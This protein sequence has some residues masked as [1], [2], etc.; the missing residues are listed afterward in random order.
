MTNLVSIIFPV[1]PGSRGARR[2]MHDLLAQTWED[3]EIVTVLNGCPDEIR[4]SFQKEKSQRVKL[5]DLGNEPNL[6]KALQVATEAACGV[7]L[8][9]MDTDDRCHPE[10]IEKTMEL[11]LAGECDVASC[12]I[13]LIDPIGNGM[14][15]YVDW[16]NQLTDHERVSA[17]RFIESPVVQPTVILRR[18]TFFE[19][20]GYLDDGF[21][22]DY[23]LWLRLLAQG[24]RFG[25]VS[26]LLYSWRDHEDRLTRNDVRFSQK[27]MLALKADALSRLDEVIKRGV[28]FCGA[29]PIAKVLA[30]ELLGRGIAVHGFFEIDPKR[31]GSICQ[32]QPI[33][34]HRDF[35]TRWRDAV[36]LAAV[37]TRG[38]R[39]IIR[40]AARKSGFEE[41]RNFWCCC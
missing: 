37:G 34:D 1:G 12:G 38:G 32:G 30:R 33:A 11:L 22:E 23:S 19:I 16:V 39:E 27:Q 35:G 7:W 13:E 36:Q 21:A 8:A 18:E 20:G 26:E 25:K 3:I 28:T 5:I 29:G 9:R 40:E 15:R 24:M 6:L 2:A 31:I 17:E 10:R 14:R 4:R 41:G